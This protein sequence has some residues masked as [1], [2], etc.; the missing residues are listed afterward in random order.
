MDN[1]P[2]VNDG[3]LSMSV[4]IGCFFCQMYISARV[5]SC[6]SQTMIA[7]LIT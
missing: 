7:G 3:G 6:H 1:L 2:F 4:V 5:A